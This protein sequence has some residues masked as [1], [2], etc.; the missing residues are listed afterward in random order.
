[1][2]TGKPV[3][4][5]EV[6]GVGEYQPTTHSR[7]C[8]VGMMDFTSPDGVA[9]LSKGDHISSKSR[10][11]CTIHHHPYDRLSISIQKEGYRDKVISFQKQKN[12]K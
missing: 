8:M 5:A 4:G 2:T 7:K 1:M 9:I 12:Y 3:V 6:S 11:E 10:K